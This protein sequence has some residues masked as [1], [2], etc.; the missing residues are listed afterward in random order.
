MKTNKKKIE[1]KL[2]VE[3]I[4]RKKSAFLIQKRLSQMRNWI[5]R[6]SKIKSRTFSSGKPEINES[7]RKQIRLQKSI[8]NSKRCN[9]LR[10]VPE[11]NR[12]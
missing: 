2:F 10:I 7:I 4:L 6:T 1:T 12:V 8:H 3:F 5:K 9:V 11:W